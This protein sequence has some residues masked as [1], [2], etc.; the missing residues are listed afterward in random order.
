[1]GK[2]R[3]EYGLIYTFSSLLLFYFLYIMSKKENFSI[4]YIFDD[5]E[6]QTRFHRQF[7]IRPIAFGRSFELE[8][9]STLPQIMEVFEF[10]GWTD[11]LKMYTLAWLLNSIA[12]SPLLMKKIRH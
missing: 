3:R 8:N 4:P 5:E 10:Q 11:F 2:Y 12:L 9:F 6:M 7:F 1:M